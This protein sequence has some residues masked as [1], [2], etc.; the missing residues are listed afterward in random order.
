MAMADGYAQASGKLAV[1]NLHVAPG[2]RQRDGHAVRRADGRLADPGDRR[3]A[4]HRISAS[5]SPCCPPTWR[6]SP[7]RLVKF[8]AQVAAPRG[9]AEAGASR[10][11]DRA[12]AADR[13]GVPVAARRH[14]QERRRHRSAGADAGGAARAWR[15]RRGQC[16]RRPVV[17]ARAAGHHGRRR[18][19]RIAARQPGAGGARRGDR[20][21]GL[22]RVRAEHRVVPLLASAVSRLD[23]ALAAGRARGAGPARSTVLGRR[24]HVHLVAA[25][26]RQADARTACR[27]SIS[28]PIRGRSARAIRRRSAFSAI[29]RRR[30][31][32]SPRRC[33]ARM[34]AARSRGRGAAQIRNR[35]PGKIEPGDALRAWRPR[36][37]ARQDT[38][39]AP[40]AAARRSARCCRRTRWCSRR[41]CRR[42]RGARSGADQ[43]A[44]DPQSFFALRGGGG[45]RLEPARRDRGQARA[46]RSPRGVAHRRRQRPLHRAGAVDRRA[47]HDDGGDLG[48]LQ[49]N[50]TSYRILK[51]RLVSD[52]R[53]GRAG[54][55]FRRHGPDRPGDRVRRLARSLGIEAHRAKTV[56]D[57][58]D[59]IAKGLKDGSALLID[60]D[61]DR[62]YKPM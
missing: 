20:R 49:H 11:Q 60:V 46:A 32:T 23:D 54:R 12:G 44:S 6:R 25:V 7:S 61:M 59:L 15:H 43:T 57:A 10:R 13:A 55:H 14:P 22:H 31:P 1:I 8:S 17:K 34:S 5:R 62:N 58:T 2:P 48:D 38:G 3:S 50:N 28:T 16:R 37:L 33:E 24:R 40:R 4:G 47:L 18:G 42:T 26:D 51:Q 9:S 36:A 56:K 19:R 53:A 29:R 30:C 21:A 45:H 52:A 41:S 39:A 27:S 35:L